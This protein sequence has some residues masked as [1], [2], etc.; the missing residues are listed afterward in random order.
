MLQKINLGTAYKL[1]GGKIS[2]EEISLARPQARE[3]KNINH[4][5]RIRKGE[6]MH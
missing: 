6:V 4:S 3:D 5:I 2:R 1:S